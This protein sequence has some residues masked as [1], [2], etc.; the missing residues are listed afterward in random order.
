LDRLVDKSLV[1]VDASGPA[2]RYRLLEPI[3]R[4]AWERLATSGEAEAVGGHHATHYLVL[5]ERAEPELRG[6]RQVHQLNR[7]EREHDNLRAA[8]RWA[9]EQ[10]DANV[11]LRL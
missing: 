9:E 2:A 6:A 7:L 5:A 4:Y 11:S 1:L 3:R 10:A 8:L